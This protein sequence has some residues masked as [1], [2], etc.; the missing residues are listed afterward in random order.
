MFRPTVAI[1][2]FIMFLTFT[3][4]LCL[5]HTLASVYTLRVYCSGIWLVCCVF[6]IKRIILNIKTFKHQNVTIKI[7]RNM[8]M[9]YKISYIGRYDWII[10]ELG[11][12]YLHTYMCRRVNTLYNN[13]AAK[14]CNKMGWEL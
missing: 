8:T 10:C 3:L 14:E 11:P 13:L 9:Q 12:Y 2:K 1:I 5:L 4:Y 7:A 6:V